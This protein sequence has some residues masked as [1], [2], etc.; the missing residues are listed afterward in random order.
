MEIFLCQKTKH[1]IESKINFEKQHM[2][3]FVYV[4]FRLHYNGQI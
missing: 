1:D 4:L 3:G 2:F